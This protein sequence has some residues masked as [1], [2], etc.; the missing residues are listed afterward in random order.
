[1]QSEKLRSLGLPKTR[2]LEPSPAAVCE[3]YEYRTRV[4][5]R[6]AASEQSTSSGSRYADFLDLGV[7]KERKGEPDAEGASGDS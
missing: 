4:A 3:R 2:K 6:A 1:M 5:A 7:C